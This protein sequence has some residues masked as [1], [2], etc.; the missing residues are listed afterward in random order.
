[1][2]RVRLGMPV[3]SKLGEGP[4]HLS[5]QGAAVP[6]QS[7]ADP[8][9]APQKPAAGQGPLSPVFRTCRLHTL[10]RASG[11]RPLAPGNLLN[12]LWLPPGPTGSPGPATLI[13]PGP[14]RTWS[15]CYRPCCPWRTSQTEGLHP[16]DTVKGKSQWGLG[17]KLKMEAGPEIRPERCQ[18]GN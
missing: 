9:H 16:P 18:P 14:V 7:E 3:A 8:Q 5:S 2:G 15:F 6:G 1:M 13:N 12:N 10:L 4:S 11:Q 17:L